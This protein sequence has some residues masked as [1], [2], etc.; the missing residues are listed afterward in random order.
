MP[1]NIY[2]NLEIDL[3]KLKRTP[4]LKYNLTDIKYLRSL[5]TEILIGW[6]ILIIII[7]GSFFFLRNNNEISL[8][9]LTWCCASALTLTLICMI[10]NILMIKKIYAFRGYCVREMDITYRKGIIF[11]KYTTIP[12]SRVQQVKITQ[13]IFGRIFGLYIIQLE[14]GSQSSL[15]LRIHGLTKEDADN[16]RSFI[17]EKM[18]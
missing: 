10:A 8:S 6:G 14:D 13:N 2:S 7:C 12:Y 4:D 5:K 16:I 3:E 9:T 15:G 18:S 1:E 11:N 17:L